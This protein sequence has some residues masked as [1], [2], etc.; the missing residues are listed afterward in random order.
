MKKNQNSITY[1]RQDWEDFQSLTAG[2]DFVA[3]QLSSILPTMTSRGQQFWDVP[4]WAKDKQTKS[5]F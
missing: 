2:Q 4:E 3:A 5:G 1:Q